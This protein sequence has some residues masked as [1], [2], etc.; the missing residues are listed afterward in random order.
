[1]YLFFSTRILCQSRLYRIQPL[2]ISWGETS[3][4]DP[5]TTPRVDGRPGKSPHFNFA[6]QHKRESNYFSY[7][8]WSNV[9][10]K[11]WND[12]VCEEIF[13]NYIRLDYYVII[14]IESLL[15]THNL[16]IIWDIVLKWPW[17]YCFIFKVVFSHMKK[18]TEYF[19]INYLS[20]G[21]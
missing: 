21:I 20:H 4:W 8:Y 12:A 6:T 2:L 19:N 18:Y 1:M 15:L 17:A 16:H 3:P 13:I 10:P 7:L 14:M 9:K 5:K 11:L